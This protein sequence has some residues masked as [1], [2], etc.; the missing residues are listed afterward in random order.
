MFSFAPG[1]LAKAALLCS[2]C[3]PGCT[4]ADDG[5]DATTSTDPL[6]GARSRS[7]TR[8]YFIA[9][10][11]V[12]WD[13][14]PDGTNVMMGRPFNDEENV[15]VEANGVDRVGSTYKKA[16][17]REYTDGTFQQLK[18]RPE[19]ERY[20][21]LLGPVIYA[22]VG[23]AIRVVFRNHGSFPYSV[24]PHG[25]SYDKAGEGAV[26][27]DGTSGDDKLDDMVMPGD[28]YTYQ[29]QV[30]E[31][32]GPGP[33]DPSSIVWLY[34][35]HVNSIA[36]E[37]AGLIGA[38]VISKASAARSNGHAKNV[39]REILSLFTVFDENA[40][41]LLDDNLHDYAPD[42]DVDDEEFGESN[43]M[44]SIN[45][46]V[47]GN[48]AMPTM[49]EGERVRWHLLALG[50]EVDLHTPHWH[51][52]TVLEQGHRTDV[53]ELLPAS[54]HTVDMVPD[55]PGT[56]MF[57]CH[58]NDHIAAGMAGMYQVSQAAAYDR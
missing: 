25:V 9:A 19:N 38:I 57:H 12:D 36:E 40:S 2:L 4:A 22:A 11:E 20:L 51:G 6:N 27:D 53:V 5:G 41:V 8:T 3:S 1:R 34:H 45:G 16:L 37:Y 54:M 32:A 15:F 39:D 58:V 23:D 35:S 24:H 18:E 47:Y 52:N 14:A 30:P 28:T 55:N 44:H 17:Y 48:G 21:G 49:I 56:W 50:T 26:S 10:D 7:K 13:Y 31:R 46:Y 43:L 33:D 42:A 29:W